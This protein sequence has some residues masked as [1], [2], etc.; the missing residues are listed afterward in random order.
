MHRIR[1]LVLGVGLLGAAAL[2][3]LFS[4][5]SCSSPSPSTPPTP[6]A[7]VPTALVIPSNLS[8]EV[9]EIQGGG[10]A[11]LKSLTTSSLSD[12]IS[13]GA[14]TI[15]EDNLLLDLLL[16]PFRD[17]SIPVATDRTTFEAT[18][19]FRNQVGDVF[20]TADGK[21]DFS[22]F[23][24][25]G[26]G[27]DEACTGCTCPVGCQS[28]LASCPSEAPEDQL[29]PICFRLWLDGERFMAG[30]FDRVPTADNPESGTIRL[31]VLNRPGFDLIGS[32][33][34][35]SY[36]QKDPK[37]RSLDLMHFLKDMAF[38]DFFA[39]RHDVVYESGPAATAKKT[40]RLQ[41][42]LFEPN[43][44]LLQYQAQFFSH[45][46]FVA[47]EIIASGI[48]TGDSGLGLDSFT[49]PICAQLSTASPAADILCSD[50]SLELTPGD[51]PS[52]PEMN[53]VQLPSESEFP[54]TPTF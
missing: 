13:V 22:A 23:D 48:F 38:P 21:L 46:D 47:L 31:T 26:D 16:S 18:L 3:P 12:E 52:L 33:L 25:D 6:P 19:S 15:A 39:R 27:S 5:A 11:A 8:I 50:L 51:F 41:S 54:Q 49:P 28:D 1:I 35:I 44:G 37:N 53:D 36:D 4:G 42:E 45:L 9:N 40:A 14:G 32:L 29:H 2:I 24:L 43:P 30:V 7:E 10:P 20:L 17:L 34:A